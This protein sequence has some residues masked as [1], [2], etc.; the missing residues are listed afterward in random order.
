MTEQQALEG[1]WAAIGHAPVWVVVGYGLLLACMAVK[2]FTEGK[3]QGEAKEWISV[4]VAMVVGAATALTSAS[5]WPHVLVLTLFV[6][7]TSSGFWS[8]VKSK[9]PKF[10]KPSTPPPTAPE[11]PKP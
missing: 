7:L 10:G 9:I 4:S 8:K 1:L 3:A 5:S 11:A 6:G 2:F